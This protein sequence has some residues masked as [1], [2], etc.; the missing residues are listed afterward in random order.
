LS[1]PSGDLLRWGVI[2]TA[3]IGRKKVIPAIKKARRSQVR[4]IASREPG[5]S[6]EVAAELGIPVA[7]G[8]YEELLADPEIDAVYIPLPNHMHLEWTLAAA[9]AGKHILCE[10]PLAMTSA[11]A[12]TMVDAARDAAVVLMEAFM[13]RLHPS[14]VAVREIVESGRL[15]E[16]TAIQSWFGYYNDDPTNI[17]NIRSIGGGA[18]YDVGCYQV[19]LSRL[20]FGGEPTRVKASITR[21]GGDGVD[22]L[23]SAILEFGDKVS[24][25]VCSIRTETDQRVHVYGSKGRLSVG[26]P[27][28]IPPGRPTEIYVTAGGQPPEAPS[29]EVITFVTADPYTVEAEVFAATVL[30]GVPAL[31]PP[32]DAVANLRVLEQIFEAAES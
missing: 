18:L 13:Y 27:F 17:R 8:S 32:E 6:A 4:A 10:K 2:S 24:S 31:F 23:T 19:N 15:G 3:D 28:N 1:T 14:W 20:L 12:Q 5:R 26:I 21:D 11:D 29:V 30:D 22:I 25:L 9:A 16:V 7:Y